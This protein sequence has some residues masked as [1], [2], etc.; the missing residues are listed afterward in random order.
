MLGARH[1]PRIR[2]LAAPA[3]AE[4]TST[5]RARPVLGWR[6]RALQPQDRSP[7]CAGGPSARCVNG[8]SFWQVANANLGGRRR[9]AALCSRRLNLACDRFPLV[10][11]KCPTSGTKTG[12]RSCSCGPALGTN[13]GLQRDHRPRMGTVRSRSRYRTV[14]PTYRVLNFASPPGEIFGGEIAGHIASEFG[15]APLCRMAE[16]AIELRRSL[17]PARR[18][19]RR[20]ARSSSLWQIASPSPRGAE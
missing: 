9:E 11:Y 18:R 16:F 4:F 13:R 1:D 2:G 14:L 15:Q 12:S 6:G 7:Q 5:H 3:L 10:H 20:C 8:Y 17:S 19:L